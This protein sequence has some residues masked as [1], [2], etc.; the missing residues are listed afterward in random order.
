MLRC[1]R[2]IIFAIFVA[3]AII[4]EALPTGGALAGEGGGKAAAE[5]DLLSL[6]P[7]NPFAYIPPQC[8][9]RTRD[10]SGAVHNPCYTCH[11]PSQPPNYAN[12]AD[13][14][15]VY[16]FPE[17]A[18]VNHWSNLFVDRRPELSAVSDEQVLAYIRTD[19]Y[20]DG[21]RL[22]LAE[23]LDGL[24]AAWD[25][26]GNGHWSG[27]QPD[28]W[29]HFDIDGYDVDP[30]GR[31]T[32]WRAFAYAPLPGG[33]WPSNG[34]ADDVSIRLPQPFREDGAG[35]ADWSIYDVNLAIVEALAK[36]SDIA[37][38]PV[39]ERRLGVD[40][41]KD[42]KLDTASRITFAFDPRNGVNMSYVGLAKQ[43]QA[44]GKLH[45]AAGLMPEGTEF[46]HSV[47]Y[48]DVADDG[49]V[50]PSAR[51]KEL[52]YA[53]KTGWQTYWSMRER[54]L[55]DL[56]EEHDYPD[57]PERFFGD[58]ESGISTGQ[59]WR[60]QGFI[61]DGRG[62]L[63]PQTY[64][65]SLTCAGCHGGVGRTVD[66]VF[67]F[68][69]KLDTFALNHGWYS[70][71]PT[72]PI[73]ALRDPLRPD[74]RG[75]YATYL[76]RNGAGDEF[77]ANLDVL[78]RYVQDAS[79]ANALA[80]L[81]TNVAPLVTPSPVR[82]LQLDKAYRLIVREQSY[83]KGRAPVIAPLDA[84]VYRNLVAGTPTGIDQPVD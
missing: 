1:R 64:E 81:A 19:N 43:L 12:D 39:D 60:F 3:L 69:R 5:G 7:T 28:I 82:A 14:Q 2:L 33:F 76:A 71:S 62:N 59:S 42:G 48:L 80:L 15:T 31:R 23:R 26:D 24:P 54:A 57:R 61:E 66:N 50:H 45:L 36:R 58:I 75:E 11:V 47:R 13:L 17:P 52:R 41:N 72:N 83:V 20:R 34:S 35:R 44:S 53:R 16:D 38:S 67:S 27:Y 8:Y 9:T 29:F 40:L 51:L 32:G 25:T 21:D 65:E 56:R 55:S 77:R 74:G 49:N 73:G 46:V 63:R 37:I 4:F 78:K 68:S 10:L 30:H 84:T 22:T 70:W 18:T 79:A 6:I